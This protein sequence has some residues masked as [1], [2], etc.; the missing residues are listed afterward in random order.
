MHLMGYS[1]QLG[2]G[3]EKVEATKMMGPST[4]SV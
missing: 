3:V 1:L 4:W 2:S